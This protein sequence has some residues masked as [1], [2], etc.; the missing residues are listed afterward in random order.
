MVSESHRW[1]SVAFGSDQCVW[2]SI[3]ANSGCQCRL[4]DLSN[5]GQSYFNG[6]HRIH[7]AYSVFFLF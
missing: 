4:D 3:L 1:L 5:E 2:L 6:K 7:V